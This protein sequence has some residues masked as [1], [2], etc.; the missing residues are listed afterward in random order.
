VLLQI[1]LGVLRLDRDSIKI[2]EAQNFLADSTTNFGTYRL[3]LH[4]IWIKEAE[5]EL[6]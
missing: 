4:Y 1:P 2:V 3:D 6:Y 5:G